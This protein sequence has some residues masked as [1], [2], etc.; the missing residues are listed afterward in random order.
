MSNLLKHILKVWPVK[1]LNHIGVQKMIKEV[2]FNKM[3]AFALVKTRIHA[4]N[5]NI[6]LVKAGLDEG[7]YHYLLQLQLTNRTTLRLSKELLD[8]LTGTNTDHRDAELDE[9]I[10]SAINRMK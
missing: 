1:G 8:D 2:D 7:P 5:P 10:R 6:E 9:K 4:I 3:P